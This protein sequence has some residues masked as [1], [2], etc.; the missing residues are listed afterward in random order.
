MVNAEKPGGLTN[1][2]DCF[3]YIITEVNQADE[4]THFSIVFLTDGNETANNKN[5]LNETRDYMKDTLKVQA[6]SGNKTSAIYAL[7]FSKDHDAELLNFLA[8]SGSEMG[9][10]IYIDRETQHAGGYQQLMKDSF[11]ECINEA[12]QNAGS[13]KRLV[14]KNDNPDFGHVLD[15]KTDYVIATKGADD[16]QS[17]VMDSEMQNAEKEL[18]WVAVDYLASCLMRKADLE[19]QELQLTLKLGRDFTLECRPAILRI[20]DAS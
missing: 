10:F 18:E 3:N 1:F 7:G 17:A 11:R 2:V 6:A 13:C 9:N 19:K 12:V 15:L 4:N 16:P 20:T 8:Q 5:K 14:I